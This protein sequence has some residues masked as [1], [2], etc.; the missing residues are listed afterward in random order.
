MLFSIAGR[1]GRS[2]LNTNVG[3]T[4]SAH[5]VEE[6]FGKNQLNRRD[7]VSFV[8]LAGKVVAAFDRSPGHYRD[9]AARLILIQQ[10]PVAA[11]FN[12][13]VECLA[14]KIQSETIGESIADADAGKSKAVQAEKIEVPVALVKNVGAEAMRKAEVKLLLFEYQSGPKVGQMVFEHRRTPS[15]TCGSGFRLGDGFCL[16]SDFFRGGAGLNFGDVLGRGI[17]PIGDVTVLDQKRA[18]A[19]ILE[20]DLDP[21]SQDRSILEEPVRELLLSAPP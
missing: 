1:G 3:F 4:F 21:L 11:E 9:R 5:P 6:V 14:V 15:I 7:I 10:G 8:S 17:D 12:L 16:G 2:R 20:Y 18:L 19:G 13:A